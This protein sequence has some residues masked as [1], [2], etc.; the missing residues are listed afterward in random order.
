MP[1]KKK[2]LKHRA[3][4]LQRKPTPAEYQFHYRLM[5]AKIGHRLNAVVGL[6][7]VDFLFPKKLLIIEVDGERHLD[8][9][10]EKKDKARD[11]WLKAAG[12]TIWRIDNYFVDSF[13][14]THITSRDDR[15]VK[16]V[17]TTMGKVGAWAIAARNK[18][19]WKK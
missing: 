18:H 15:S 14:L 8:P 10:V 1:T 5:K 11:G 13:D 17:G 12:F 16:E 4:Q 2:Q 7:I 6:Y 3:K 9:E 19:R